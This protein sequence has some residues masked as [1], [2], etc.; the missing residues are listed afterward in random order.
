MIAAKSQSDVCEWAKCYNIRHLACWL[1]YFLFDFVF[2][3]SWI[4]LKLGREINIK[5][6]THEKHVNTPLNEYYADII[7]TCMYWFDQKKVICLQLFSAAAVEKI[8]KH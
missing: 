5:G 2:A 8:A 1:A 4:L 7:D 3:I 6:E